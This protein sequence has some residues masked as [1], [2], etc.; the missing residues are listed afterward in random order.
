MAPRLLS[1]CSVHGCLGNRVFIAPVWAYLSTEPAGQGQFHAWARGAH[2]AGGKS[3]LWA[4]QKL[5]SEGR[6]IA[7]KYEP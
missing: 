6:S 7:T 1:H 4:T 5:F 3:L 2:A